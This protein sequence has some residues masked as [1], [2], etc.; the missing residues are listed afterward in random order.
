MVRLA[1]ELAEIRGADR[2]ERTVL[3]DAGLAA[4]SGRIQVHEDQER[5]VEEVIAELL[6]S[7]LATAGARRA[8]SPSLS[9]QRETS[10]SQ[11]APATAAPAPRTSA[12]RSR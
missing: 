10:R 11:T 3:L 4:M 1:G 2:S 8:S 7:A 5:T 6:D 9:P 12:A